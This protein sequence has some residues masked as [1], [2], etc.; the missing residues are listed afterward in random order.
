MIDDDATTTEDG[1]C[2]TQEVNAGAAAEAGAAT[3]AGA[4]GAAAEEIEQS[5]APALPPPRP[6]RRQAWQGR[7]RQRREVLSRMPLAIKLDCL[8]RS[9]T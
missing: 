8:N 3:A 2:S 9:V 5:A 1:A 7:S 6:A 4:A